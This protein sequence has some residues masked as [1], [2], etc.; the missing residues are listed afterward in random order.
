M[1]ILLV[2]KHTS[3]LMTLSKNSGNDHRTVTPFITSFPYQVDHG[4]VW[5]PLYQCELRPVSLG[6]QKIQVF[7]PGWCGSVD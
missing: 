4:G 6:P 3:F 1:W 7:Y 5:A 2:G